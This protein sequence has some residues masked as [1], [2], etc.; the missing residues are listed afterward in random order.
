MRGVEKAAASGTPLTLG[1]H[2]WQRREAFQLYGQETCF[3]HV[4][5]LVDKLGA[6][7]VICDSCLYL[8][9]E[10]DLV[11][12]AMCSCP[13]PSGGRTDERADGWTDGRADGRAGDRAGGRTGGRTRARMYGRTDGLTDERTDRRASG[14]RADGRRS[15]MESTKLF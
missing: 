12:V 13:D 4:A 10:G 3:Q 9:G 7:S 14:R 5:D 15:H 1:M 11:G 8:K 2:L 6:T